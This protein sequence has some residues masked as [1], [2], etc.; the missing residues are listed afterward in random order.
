LLRGERY[1]EAQG[2]AL[3]PELDLEALAR[4]LHHASQAEAVRAFRAWLRGG[5]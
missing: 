3:L 5:K 2:S 1:E 4:H